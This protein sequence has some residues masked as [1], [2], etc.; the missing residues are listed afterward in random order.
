MKELYSIPNIS[1]YNGFSC[2]VAVLALYSHLEYNY[3]AAFV[4]YATLI[5]FI[6]F[7]ILRALFLNFFVCF[8][9]FLMYGSNS[10]NRNLSQNICLFSVF[11][12]LSSKLNSY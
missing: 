7:K 10:K 12:L 11:C 1:V 4:N 5:F 9:F 2:E 8:V 6:I 3:Q